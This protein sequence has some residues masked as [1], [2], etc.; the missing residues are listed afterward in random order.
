MNIL[1]W[2][3]KEKG[4]AEDETGRE[5]YPL[6]GC[7]SE[8]TLGDSKGQGEPGVLHFMGSQRVTHDL[9]MEQQQQMLIRISGW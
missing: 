7:A 9:A 2:R 4:E 6:S 8:Q 3:Q 5:H 1:N